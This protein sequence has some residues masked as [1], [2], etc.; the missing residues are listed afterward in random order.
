MSQSPDR[1]LD[2]DELRSFCAAAELG[3]LGR[4]A[5]RL[6]VSQPAVSK[7]L[8]H[9]EVMAGTRLLER[10]SLG[11]KLTPAG[12]RLYEE[13]RRLLQQSDLFGEVLAGLRQSDGPIRL[14]ASHSAT[15]ALVA[16]LLA[17]R[18]PRH[19]TVELLIANSSV[20]RDLVADDQA[21]LGVAAGRPQRTTYAGVREMELAPDAVVY[22]VPPGH[23]WTGRSSV[24]I[25]Q[26]T[27]TPV[28]VRDPASNSRWT[29]EAVLREHG[30]ELPPPLVEAATPHAALREAEAR[31]APVL[32]SRHVLF[33]SGFHE[34]AI[35]GLAFPRNFV[36]LLPAHGEPSEQVQALMSD[37]RHHAATWCRAEAQPAT[38]RA[39][40]GSPR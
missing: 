25:A 16:E 20:V 23:G 2:L 18:E 32:L 28:V 36:L 40:R 37:L 29:V 27:G 3:S 39:G 8:A 4:A 11:V 15:H 12:R 6:H 24:T 10:S 30:L 5:V 7:R 13:G 34:L 14:A 1:S 17:H 38:A 33:G 9:L 19:Q 26:F 22:A 21:D 31:G 35:D